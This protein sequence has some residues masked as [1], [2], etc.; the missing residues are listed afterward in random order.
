LGKKIIIAASN[1]WTSAFQVGSHHYARQF[2]KNGWKVLFISDPISPFHFFIRDKEQVYERYKIYKG[3][4]DSKDSNIKIYVP[5]ALFTPNERPLFNSKFVANKWQYFTFPNIMKFLRSTGFDTTD[6]LWFDSLIQS[7]FIDNVK[8][9]KSILRIS[10]RLDA[11]KKINA[12]LTGLEKKLKEKVDLIFYSAKNLKDYIIDFEKKSYH[13][14]NGVD[15]EHFYSGKKGIPDDLKNIPKPRAIYVGAIDEWF[16]LGFLKDVA[17]KSRNLS[18]V[19]IG[20]YKVDVTILRQE[21]NIF[22]LGRK[23]FNLIPSYISNCDIG[24]IT[25]NAN[26][27]VVNTINPIKLYEYMACGLPVVSTNW[28]ELELIKSP[29]YLAGS[30]DDFV[31][32]LNNF[33]MVMDKETKVYKEAF[34]NFAAKNSWDKRYKQIIEIINK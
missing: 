25:F 4:I 6:L 15:F 20:S 9:K 31:N 28:K 18:F 5:F 17:R 23:S 12:N 22:L 7:F 30:I 24:I 19:L 21:P 29:A 1:Y 27:P 10:D 3:L 33:L 32:G 2:A 14:P 13:I 16:D 11:F 8:Y 34:I 26:H